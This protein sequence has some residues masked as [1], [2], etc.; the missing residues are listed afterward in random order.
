MK[1]KEITVREYA[2][3]NNV[4]LPKARRLLREMGY[5]EKTVRRKAPMGFNMKRWVEMKVFVVPE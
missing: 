2:R 5:E 3:D 1:S 4:S